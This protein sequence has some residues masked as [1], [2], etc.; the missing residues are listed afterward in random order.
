MPLQVRVLHLGPTLPR[1]LQPFL[2]AVTRPL[3][4]HDVGVR[5]LSLFQR[6]FWRV[7]L[8][9]VGVPVDRLTFVTVQP[10]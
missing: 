7:D 10:L 2:G 9:L 4:I 1:R 3:G 6:R 8:P 5:L